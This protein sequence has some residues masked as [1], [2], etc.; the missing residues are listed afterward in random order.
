MGKKKAP[1]N[2]KKPCNR[3]K[4]DVEDPPPRAARKRRGR[5][6]KVLANSVDDAKLRESLEH[7]GSKTI[8]DIDADGNCL[9]R[10]LSDQLY[11]DF[12]HQ[13]SETRNEVCDYLEAF[14]EEF[15]VFL[16]LDEEEEDEDA[17]DFET[18]VNNMRQ[19]GEW[20]GNV[21]LV[22]AARLYR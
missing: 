12:G 7:D 21:E 14:E 18:Y 3:T 2:N 10:S 15:S 6:T 17:A 20:A 16:V 9:F 5:N 1:K 11:W 22:A 4:S 13:H 19:D 8:I